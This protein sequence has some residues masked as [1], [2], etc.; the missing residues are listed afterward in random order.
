MNPFKNIE[1]QGEHP[2][3]SIFVFYSSDGKSVD[4]RYVQMLSANAVNFDE[5]KILS[6]GKGLIWI[7]PGFLEDELIENLLFLLSMIYLMLKDK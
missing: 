2:V 1:G 6:F 7:F 4:F 3:T 5:S